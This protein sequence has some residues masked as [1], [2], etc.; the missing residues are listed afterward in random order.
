MYEKIRLELKF[1]YFINFGTK[2]IPK[3]EAK[4]MSEIKKKLITKKL[5]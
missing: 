4:I 5:Q 3:E 1:S 2:H